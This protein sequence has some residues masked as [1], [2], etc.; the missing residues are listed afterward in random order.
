M[1]DSSET[2]RG[3][4]PAAATQRPGTAT[5]GTRLSHG[6]A[7]EAAP[8]ARVLLL[9][10]L[11]G[12]R[13]IEARE[14]YAHPRNAFWPIVE[15]LFGI[16]S[17]LPYRQ[18]I[19]R[20]TAQRIAL[21]DVLGASRRPG[22]LDAAIDLASAQPNDFRALFAAQR[23][24]RLV[25]FN[26]RKAAELFRRLVA[27]SLDRGPPDYLTLPSTSPAHAAMSFADKLALWSAVTRYL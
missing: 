4:P 13:S 7:A 20:L 10:S 1:S 8:G 22:S 24:L 9:G 11:P 2:A 12:V 25:A 21:W 6:F 15:A 27:P 17:A 3:R 14:Y 26:G 19:L 18:R 16:D 5:A 23:E